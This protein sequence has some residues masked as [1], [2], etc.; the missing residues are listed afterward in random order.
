MF[1]NVVLYAWP[2][3]VLLLF[4]TRS[5]TSAVLVALI[6][7][8]L[9]L[10]T[11]ISLDLP[12]LP[13]LNK[14]TIPA[15]AAFLIAAM[16]PS[17]RAASHLPGWVPRGILLNAL[18]LTLVV[19]SFL[20]VMTN[21]D[22]L[23]YGPMFL[24]SLRPWDALSTILSTMTMLLPFLLGRRLLAHPD[25]Q[26]QA[27]VALVLAGVVYSFLALFEIRMSPQLSNMV[28]GFFPHAWEQHVRAG[29][30]RPIVFLTHGLWLSIFF[31]A[32]VLAAFG[33]VRTSDGQQKILFLSAGLWLL[34]TLILS[35]SL[36]ALIITLILAP[37]LLFL[38]RR[39]QMLIAAG[40]AA[41]VLTY[42]LLRGADVVPVE[43]VLELVRNVSER[44]YESLDFR[45]LNEDLLLDK[46]RERPFFGWGGWGR[47]FV[48]D[49]EGRNITITDGYWVLII[50]QG[51]WLRYLAE[52]GLLCIPAFLVVGRARRHKFGPETAALVVVLA[53]N[54]VDLIPN[55]T[56]TPLTWMIAGAIWGRL[57]LG[58]VTAEQTDPGDGAESARNPMRHTRGT[59]P[60][61]SR[62]K[63]RIRRE[64]RVTGGAGR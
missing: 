30:Y 60:R 61:Y 39:G 38:H 2:V 40:L 48:F 8:Y 43:R 15:I 31:A 11:T 7:G 16:M 52:F 3:V 37:A 41:V 6:G 10:P 26:R 23:R 47:N 34:L 33:L 49:E 55:A 50:G 20:T 42:P 14:D 36:G 45:I 19:A 54:L 4:L 28:Y 12:G 53:A 58:L 51:G 27:L 18:L 32:T 59:G 44:G 13:S 21:G 46:A 62:Q 22:P 56:I 17:V 9:F 29:G 64:A 25:Q 24:P 63:T 57:E 5:P 1:A 35:K